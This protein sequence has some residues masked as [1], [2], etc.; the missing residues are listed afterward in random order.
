MDEAKLTTTVEQHIGTRG[1]GTR[2]VDLRTITTSWLENADEGPW[3]SLSES[4]REWWW[5]Y[6][7][8]V[9]EGRV[10]LASLDCEARK[11]AQDWIDDQDVDVDNYAAKLRQAVEYGKAH[12]HEYEGPRLA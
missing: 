6:V 2:V 9:H 10:A 12:A 8:A 11:A 5:D 1:D 7:R 3:E 4:D